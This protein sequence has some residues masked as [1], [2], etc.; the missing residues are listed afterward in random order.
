MTEDMVRELDE[1]VAGARVLCGE[2]AIKQI[3]KAFV[4]AAGD[5]NKRA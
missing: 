1:L 3:D 4:T 5:R 2:I